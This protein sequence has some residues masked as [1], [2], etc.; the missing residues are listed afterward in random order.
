[1]ATNQGVV[2]SNPASR[3]TKNNGLASREA[4]PFVFVG[5]RGSTQGS[6]EGGIATD[7]LG[8]PR[9]AGLIRYQRGRITVLDRE[10][11]E[12]RTCECY[13]VVRREYERLLAVHPVT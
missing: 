7:Y 8:S 9:R 13:V 5:L 2:G 10:G 12:R 11:L 1:M 6:T 3:A 4:N